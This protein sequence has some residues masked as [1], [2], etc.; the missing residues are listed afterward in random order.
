MSGWRTL[1][2]EWYSGLYGALVGILGFQ[3]AQRRRDPAALKTYIVISFISG[4]SGSLDVVQLLLSHA[5][6]LSAAL[7]AAANH[8]HLLTLCSTAASLN[9]DTK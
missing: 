1:R 6:I 3:S 4:L 9:G 5:P 8:A 7:P 2:G